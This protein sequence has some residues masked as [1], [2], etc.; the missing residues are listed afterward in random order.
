[1]P[2]GFEDPDNERLTRRHAAVFEGARCLIPGACYMQPS[3]A[4]RAIQMPLT[5]AVSYDALA[6]LVSAKQLAKN[7]G[8]GREADAAV[9]GPAA[10]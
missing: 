2:A 9:C 1:M 5:A 4:S 8:R 7:C 3:G 10:S 6:T